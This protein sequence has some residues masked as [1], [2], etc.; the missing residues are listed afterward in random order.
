MFPISTF[1][2]LPLIGQKVEIRRRKLS[3]K[4]DNNEDKYLYY[5]QNLIYNEEWR[6]P[7]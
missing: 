6:I 5:I 1:Q 3:S 7:A 2:S 4:F